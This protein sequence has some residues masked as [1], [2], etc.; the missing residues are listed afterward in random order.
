MDINSNSKHHEISM[1]HRQHKEGFIKTSL[2]LL[3]EPRLHLIVSISKKFR[4]IE[5]Y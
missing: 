1:I 5:T 4:Y 2:M 3:T